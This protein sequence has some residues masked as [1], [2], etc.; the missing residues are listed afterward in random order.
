MFDF[1]GNTKSGLIAFCVKSPEKIGF[2]S[3]TVSEKPNLLFTNR[4][5]NPLPGQN[6]RFEY[7]HLAESW[8]HKKHVEIK[9]TLL[10]LTPEEKQKLASLNKSPNKQNI[11]ICPGSNWPNKVL[12]EDTLQALLHKIE[13]T[14]PTKFW[15]I[16]GTE[17]EKG[18]CA[19]LQLKDRQICEKMSLPL[20][21]NWMKQMDKVIA[22]DSLPLHLAA[23]AGTPTYS[24]FGASS[25]SKY[26][27][28]GSQH[29]AYQGTCPYGKTF[30]RRCDILRTCPTGACIHDL[31]PNTLFDHYSLHVNGQRK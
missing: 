2:G 28:L 23:E 22:M 10:K 18:V 26:Q 4:T 17:Q 13:E 6:T 29:I 14:T 9:T 15:L 24:I 27:P 21:Q 19:R 16:Y 3:T 5:F 1:Q 12:T 31:K 20:L 25:A 7:L 30:A 8:A 11:M